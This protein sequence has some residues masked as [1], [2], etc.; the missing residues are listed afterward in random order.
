M[1]QNPYARKQRQLKSFVKELQ[2]HLVDQNN[3]VSTQ[4]ERL[5]L[6]IRRLVHELIFVICHAELKKILGTAAI[7]IGIS[8]TNQIS[9]QTWI[10]R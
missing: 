1:K 4:I 8:F 2:L 9:A 7:I 3:N 5:I 6:K 10:F